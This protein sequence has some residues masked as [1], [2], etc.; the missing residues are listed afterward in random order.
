MRHAHQ[1]GGED[2]AVAC[3]RDVPADEVRARL[4]SL[5]G[6]DPQRCYISH[7]YRQFLGRVAELQRA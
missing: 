3:A 5:A 4:A 1:I 7:V 6:I 2:P